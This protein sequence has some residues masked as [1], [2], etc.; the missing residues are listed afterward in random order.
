[1]FKQ[2]VFRFFTVVNAVCKILLVVLISKAL[3][4]ICTVNDAAPALSKLGGSLAA[5]CHKALKRSQ[6]KLRN[7]LKAAITF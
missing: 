5:P 2:I 4:K 1:V 7:L 6:R 3:I